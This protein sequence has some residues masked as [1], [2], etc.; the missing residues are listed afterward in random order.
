MKTVANA[1][2][3]DDAVRL[4]GNRY[5]KCHFTDCQLI[6]AG[7]NETDF[8]DCTFMRCSWTFDDAAL[9]TLSFL[10]TL[11]HGAGPVGGDLVEAIFA[12]VRR[13]RIELLELRDDGR[14]TSTESVKIS[15][16]KAS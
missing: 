4:D 13:A 5:V 7:D 2:F 12:S 10:T 1:T 6:Y 11:Y 8:Q 16:V 9:R 3:R 14:I 15:T